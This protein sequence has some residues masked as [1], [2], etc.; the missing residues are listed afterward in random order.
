MNRCRTYLV[1]LA[2]AAFGLG[3]PV[4]ADV[5]DCTLLHGVAA[6]SLTEQVAT[7]EGLNLFEHPV[8]RLL[9][10]P[11]HD[12]A[13]VPTGH[14]SELLIDPDG[15]VTDVVLALSGNDMPRVTLS[16]G[17]LCL[18]REPG[19]TIRLGLTMT[20]KQAHMLPVFAAP[21]ATDRF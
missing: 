9:H 16:P 14:T 1:T 5:Q 18:F 6:D 13:R 2:L 20:A 19:G 11:V 3:S 12:L 15:A 21:L 7:A 17:D 10:L 8:D 4:S